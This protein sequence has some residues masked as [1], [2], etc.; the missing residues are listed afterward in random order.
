MYKKKTE[1]RKD[2]EE[3]EDE[4]EGSIER[5]W[6][7]LKKIIDEAMVKE[8]WKQKRRGVGHKEWWN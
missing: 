6:E 1:E 8:E 7:R 2:K 3:E 4:I 5:R